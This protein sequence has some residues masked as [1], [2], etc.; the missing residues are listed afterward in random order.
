MSTE[1]PAINSSGTFPSVLGLRRAAVLALSTL[2]ASGLVGGL[3]VGSAF[4]TTA[5]RTHSGSFDVL[6]AGSFLDLM[7]QQLA[8][9]FHKATG[10][11]VGGFSDGSSALASEIKGGTEVGDVFISASPT[12]NATLEGAANGSWVSSYDEF[13]R[14]PLMLGYNPDSKFARDLQTKPWYDVVDRSGFLLGR[15]DPATDPKGVLA[16]DALAGVGMSY[17]LPSLAAL[18]TSTSN[19]FAET[20]L[21]GEL[22]AGQ[23]DAGFFYAVEASAAHIKTVPLTSTNLAAQYTV[24]VLKNAPHEAAAKAFVRFLIGA[25]GEKILRA[26]G[27]TPISPA[28]V[29]TSSGGNTTTTSQP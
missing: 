29:F 9:A 6:Y 4:A 13:G 25:S 27:I 28:R 7:Q 26:N 5:A 10:Y 3:F 23:L 14:S 17:D 21:V 11:T 19:V 8:P 12:V 2:L 15:T 20:S 22:Q 24:A 16:V 1:W 18:A